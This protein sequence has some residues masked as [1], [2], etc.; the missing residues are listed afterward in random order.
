[1]KNKNLRNLPV[2]IVSIV[3][4]FDMSRFDYRESTIKNCTKYGYIDV[5][6]SLTVLK[7]L[8]TQLLFPL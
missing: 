8:N 3:F 1:M 7:D 2:N 6:I 4:N 5:S